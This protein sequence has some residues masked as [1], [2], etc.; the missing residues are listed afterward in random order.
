MF[1]PPGAG[2]RA[3]DRLSKLR[4]HY[5]GFR[6]EPS[7]IQMVGLQDCSLPLPTLREQFYKG[8]TDRK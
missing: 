6:E 7:E 1:V 3:T 4:R 2:L 8:F 5:R